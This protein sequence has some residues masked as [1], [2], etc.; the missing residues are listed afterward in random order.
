MILWAGDWPL[1]SVPADGAKIVPSSNADMFILSEEG[2]FILCD[3]KPDQA[4]LDG[5][6][7]ACL[8]WLSGGRI[9]RSRQDVP[10][11]CG[12]GHRTTTTHHKMKTS[13]SSKNKISQTEKKDGN[14]FFYS[15]FKINSDAVSSRNLNWCSSQHLT[16]TR[17]GF[18]FY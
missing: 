14:T 16:V 11:T 2:V 10:S 4:C 9:Q 13:D 12:K 17:S 18:Q 3:K 8:I 1:L 15:L 6:E 7:V 5:L